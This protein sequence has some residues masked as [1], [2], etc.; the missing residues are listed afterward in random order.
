[1]GRFLK[2]QEVPQDG[3]IV[4]CPALVKTN[5]EGRSRTNPRP[6]PKLAQGNVDLSIEFSGLEL[7]PVVQDLPS[8]TMYI[9]FMEQK[10]LKK[11]IGKKC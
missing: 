9:K 6:H 3:K 8:T 5:L 11:I 1:M 7:R 10:I 2:P 4:S